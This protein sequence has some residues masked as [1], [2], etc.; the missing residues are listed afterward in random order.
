MTSFQQIL[1]INSKEKV[2]WEKKIIERNNGFYATLESSISKSSSKIVDLNECYQLKD[3]SDSFKEP[4]GK[5]LVGIDFNDCYSSEEVSETFDDFPSK[6]DSFITSGDFSPD[7]S[8]TFSEF[9]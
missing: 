8:E 2:E 3:E 5:L 9:E 7:F 6:Y 4:I 1:V